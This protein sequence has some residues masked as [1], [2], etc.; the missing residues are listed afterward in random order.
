MPS[1]DLFSL[2]LGFLLGIISLFLANRMRGLLP[3]REPPHTKK[4]KTNN[5]EIQYESKLRKFLLRK[6]QGLHIAAHICPLSD[7]YI[8]QNLIS[9]PIHAHFADDSEEEPVFFRNHPSLT[10]VP[11]LS[12]GY[13][14]P[15][16]TLSQALS[17]GQNIAIMGKIGSGKT[18]ALANLV[19]EILESRC[20]QSEFN[21]YLPIYFH[22]GDFNFLG[23]PTDFLG[24][25]AGSINNQ[26]PD[27][28]TPDILN[29]L[30]KYNSQSRLLVLIDGLDE[31]RPQN[32]DT[33]VKMLQTIHNEYPN[34]RMVTT[35]GLYYTGDLHRAGFA[36]LP[37]RPPDRADYLHLLLCWRQ[38]W[39]ELLPRELETSEINE[40]FVITE[41]WL[42]QEAPLPSFF[43]MTLVV[44]SAFSHD[45]IPNNR[46]IIPYLQHQTEGITSIDTL[47]TIAEQMADKGFQGVQ[48]SDL[49]DRL[50]IALPAD[51]TSSSTTVTTED[52]AKKLINND[53]L[54]QRGNFY[55]FSNPSIFCQLLSFSPVYKKNTDWKFLQR[56]PMENQITQ[57]AEIDENYLLSWLNRDGHF[58]QHNI[59]LVLDHLVNRQYKKI[60]LSV[61]FPKL[62]NLIVAD[63]TPLSIKIKLTAII[64]Y[65]NKT[66]FSQLLTRLEKHPS[67]NCRKI[68][69]YFYGFD[70]IKAH[71]EYII[72]CTNDRDSSVRLFGY[73]ALINRFDTNSKNLLTEL[74]QNSFDKS[75]QIVAELLAQDYEKGHEMLK[76]YSGDDHPSCR[77]NVI[78]GLRLI[79]EDWADKLLNKINAD[80]HVW[81]VRD[82]AA[83]ALEKKWDPLQ[84][85]PQVPRSPAED[86]QLVKIAG[87]HG[88]GI[89]VTTYPYE[90]LNNLLQTDSYEEMLIAIQ[91]LIASPNQDTFELIATKTKSDNPIREIACQALI[92]VGLRG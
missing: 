57:V 63:E 51:R 82:A 31:L 39:N 83:H 3:K 48:L 7:I 30:Q 90:L 52:L 24:K 10:D 6:V 8:P 16:L 38:V 40:S 36:A 84:Y 29:I 81:M 64:Y 89:P 69:A 4:N 5:R 44:L 28:K 55:Q 34:I 45:R 62:V 78:Y 11:E 1:L 54:T 32:F 50:S 79:Q 9:S 43:E 65:T 13:P 41:L 56:S 68:C 59:A 19:I 49:V 61:V 53:L 27:L 88:Q 85:S 23:D 42:K 72:D 21:S 80:D 67:P 37:I 17:G 58:Y 26:Y 2:V 47:V 15:Q 60:D 75:G 22:T 91:Y 35:C 87:N 92:E 46:P 73:M 33:A 70:H 76:E 20:G 77:R 18:T 74:L 14:L 66:I 12:I 25:L 71:Q 86:P